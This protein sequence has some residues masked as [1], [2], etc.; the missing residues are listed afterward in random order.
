MPKEVI[1]EGW[2]QKKGLQKKVCQT[3][4]KMKFTKKLKKKF[5]MKFAK[6]IETTYKSALFNHMSALYT[7]FFLSSTLSRSFGGCGSL[8]ECRFLIFLVNY[9][10][11]LSFTPFH[12]WQRR[13]RKERLWNS[14]KK[15]L[16]FPPITTILIHFFF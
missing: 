8:Y 4:F 1:V 11:S 5:K 10:L 3:K 2:C 13:K 7:F 6:N 12:V 14:L 15:F 16:F 9:P